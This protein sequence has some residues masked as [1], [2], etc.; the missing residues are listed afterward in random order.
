PNLP[1]NFPTVDRFLNGV[2]TSIKSVDLRLASF[3]NIGHLSRT[4]QGYVTKLSQFNGRVW[5]GR[6]VLEQDITSRQLLLAIPPG[7]SQAQMAELLRLQR[8]A[9]DTY[10]IVINVVVVQ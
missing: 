5:A 9:Y 1:R 2:A 10:Q 8:W 7:A 6:A 3:Q 4:V